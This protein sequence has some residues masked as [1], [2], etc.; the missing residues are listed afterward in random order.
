MGQ[1][2]HLLHVG[3]VWYLF[4]GRVAYAASG[5]NVLPAIEAKLDELM[6]RR[7]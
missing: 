6:K 5:A 2:R 1:G 7:R 4:N 3:E